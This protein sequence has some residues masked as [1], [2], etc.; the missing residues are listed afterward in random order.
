M[1][2]FVRKL[3]PLFALGVSA[4]GPAWVVVKQAKPNP[5]VG[6]KTFAVEPI[7]FSAMKIGDPGKITEAEWVAKKKPDEV[8]KFKSDLQGSKDRMTEN[9]AKALGAIAAR[10]GV[11]VTAG[12]QPG[13]WTIKPVVTELEPGFNAFVMTQPAVVRLQI[14]IIDPQGQEVDVAEMKA[15]RD[16]G[17]FGAMITR[18]GM[19]GDDLGNRAARYVTSRAAQ[20]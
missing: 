3:V 18:L 17:S 9:F 1:Q 11:T 10:Q 19:C 2:N 7:D 20:K 4:C 15:T 14:H 6:Q 5:M 13:V 12:A 16:A 8:E